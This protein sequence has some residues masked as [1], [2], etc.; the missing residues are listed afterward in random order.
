MNNQL[1]DNDEYSDLRQASKVIFKEITDESNLSIQLS[2]ACDDI[3]DNLS[4]T[5][6]LVGASD[7]TGVNIKKIQNDTSSIINKV[8]ETNEKLEKSSEIAASNNTSIAESLNELKQGSNENKSVFQISFKNLNENQLET[9]KNI[10]ES[11]D[12]IN[13]QNNNLQNKMSN[14]EEVT[15]EYRKAS[16][17]D[18]KNDFN[19]V[20]QDLIKIIDLIVSLEK[21]IK[22]I[23]SSNNKSLTDEMA[24]TKEEL[25]NTKKL[26]D[27]KTTNFTELNNNYTNL[28]S[29]QQKDV[30][31]N[32]EDNHDELKEKAKNTNKKVD[33]VISLIDKDRET[34]KENNKEVESKFDELKNEIDQIKQNSTEQ[35]KSSNLVTRTLLGL[36]FIILVVILIF[37]FI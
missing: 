12:K 16:D 21:E 5:K 2:E 4:L 36:N 33:E 34:A 15:T 27:E 37:Q 35:F 24:E 29:K 20:N 32:V 30:L 31:K 3:G 6:R 11:L 13:E 7:K 18:L 23:Y 1:L 9:K 17:K 28:V 19:S 10:L 14:F 22:V 26:I 25:I 8:D